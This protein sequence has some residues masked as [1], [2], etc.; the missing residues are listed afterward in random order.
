M[1]GHYQTLPS[2]EQQQLWWN[3]WNQTFLR[4]LHPE[5]V[6]QGDTALSLLRLLNLRQPQILEVGCANGWLCEKLVEFGAVTGIDIADVSIAE[7]RSRVPS[8]RFIV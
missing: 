2:P 8:T 3:D 6:R 1:K 5:K 7:A 4:N